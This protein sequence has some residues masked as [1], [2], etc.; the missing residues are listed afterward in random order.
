M[1]GLLSK[2][3]TRQINDNSTER[4]CT[5]VTENCVDLIKMEEL[6]TTIKSLRPR[7]SPSS[8]RINN[9]F[10]NMHQKLFTYVF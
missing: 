5:T 3:W 4:K 10:T 7:K 2:L 8:D 9:E 6:E 1:A